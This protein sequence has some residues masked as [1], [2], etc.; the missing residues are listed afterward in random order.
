MR[1][2][3]CLMTVGVGGFN[4]VLSSSSATVLP[5][6]NEEIAASAGLMKG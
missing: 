6:G 3:S 4:T 1:S 5:S 2:S